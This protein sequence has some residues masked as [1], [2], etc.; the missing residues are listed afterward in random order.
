KMDQSNIS[1]H[2]FLGHGGPYTPD[3]Q[4][5]GG[6]VME[7]QSHM[8]IRPPGTSSLLNMGLESQWHYM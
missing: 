5:M 8:G 3:G 1:K 7:G 6:F 4:P 2:D